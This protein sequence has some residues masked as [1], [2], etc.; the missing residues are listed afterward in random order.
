[1]VLSCLL[2]TADVDLLDIVRSAFRVDIGLE[3]RADSASALDFAARRH[4]DG[5][6][7]DLDDIEGGIRTVRA[8]REGR[9]NKL[10]TIFAVLNGK[11]SV[12]AA[13]NMD[14]NYVLHK[15]V[16]DEVFR[17][18]LESALPKMK[19]EHRRYFRHKVDLPITVSWNNNTACG[20]LLNVSESGLAF[21]HFAAPS[22]LAGTVTV[23]FDLPATIPHAFSATAEIVWNDNY[24]T[25]VRLLHIVPSS[26]RT[27]EEWLM[28]LE[29]KLSFQKD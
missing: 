23:R 5:F 17:T 19:S 6:V 7:L 13:L 25:G 27:F 29:A 22:S 16:R 21:R 15:P 4:V 18:H 14:V 3:F 26:R 8:I 9:S 11:T 28:S 24:A 10:S 20:K 1:M 2:V 12:S